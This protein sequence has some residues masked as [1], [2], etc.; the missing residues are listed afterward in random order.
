VTAYAFPTRRVL[1]RDLGKAGL[2]ILVL[3]S[4][5][6]AAD[7]TT[8]STE[9]GSDSTEPDPSAT[10][11]PAPSSTPTTQA[12][13]SGHQWARANLGFVSAYVLY[14]RGESAVVDTGVAGSEASIGE[15]LTTAG[16]GWESVGHVI[17][18][19]K[20][21]DHQGSLQGVL[22]SAT[23]ATWYAGAEDMS[24]IVANS[25][26][27][28]VGDGD[29]VFGLEIIETPGHTPGH[30]SV[31]DPLGRILVVGDSARG[32]PEGGLAGPN[33]QFSEDLTL[34]HESVRKMAGF[35]YEVV[36]VGHGEPVLEGGTAAMTALAATLG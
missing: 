21:N 30:I 11:A 6:C 7:D 14:R 36:L 25:P 12:S 20:H 2:A 35:D 9:G 29:S 31:L 8:P 10:T 17:V 34:A 19:H 3:G 26:G 1:L 22:D 23:G 33:A 4:A 24:A 5:A 13:V 18:T 15:A 32:G 27:M 16:L 28:P